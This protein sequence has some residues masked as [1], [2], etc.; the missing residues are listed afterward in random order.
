MIRKYLAVIFLAA[1][2]FAGYV[3]YDQNLLP[4][5]IPDYFNFFIAVLLFLFVPFLAGVVLTR[6]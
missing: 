3:V 2:F 1:V 6:K 5:W 4:G